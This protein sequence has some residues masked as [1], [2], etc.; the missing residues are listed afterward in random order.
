MKDEAIKL[1]KKVQMNANSKNKV[2]GNGSDG[3]DLLVGSVFIIF[4]I[5]ILV[6]LFKSFYTVDIEEEAVVTRFGQYLDTT[7]PGLHFKIPFIDDV[8]K[9]QSKKSKKRYLDLERLDF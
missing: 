4:C 2:G 8:Y 5:F 6:A 9:V 7:Q 3:G 1:V